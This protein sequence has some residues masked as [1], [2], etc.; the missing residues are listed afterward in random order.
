MRKKI[1][2]ILLITLLI[3]TIVL[4]A[5]G[6]NITNNQKKSQTTNLYNIEFKIDINNTTSNLDDIFELY[7]GQL[8]MF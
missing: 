3:I 2:T 6:E 1:V 4:P 7:E 8:L 5:L